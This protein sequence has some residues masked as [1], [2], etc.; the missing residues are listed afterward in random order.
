MTTFNPLGGGILSGRYLEQDSSDGRLVSDQV[1]QKRYG[2][3]DYAEVVRRFVEFAHE[4]DVHPVT[5]AVAWCASHPAVTAPII[6]ARNVQQVL[7]A[8]AAASYELPTD[9]REAIAALSPK[10]PVATDRSEEA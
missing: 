8:L 6:G 2:G 5:L 3:Y 1:Y 9:V 10:P 4:L 7:P